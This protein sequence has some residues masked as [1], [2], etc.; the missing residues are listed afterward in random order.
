[1]RFTK[2]VNEKMKVSQDKDVDELPGTQPS[3]YYSGVDKGDK[4]KRAKQFARQA[5]MSDDDP[6]AY[7]PAPG[8]KDTKTKPS[9]HTKKF[10]QMYGEGGANPAQQAAI[11][12]SKKEKAGKP[13][14]DKE[15]KSLKK[16]DLKGNMKHA[17][18]TL[19]KVW[20]RKKKLGPKHDIGYY[21]AQI[22][23]SYRDV[24]S[25]E[26]AKM[27][28]EDVSQ[29][30]INDLEKFADRIL[31]KF[32][33]D[34]EFTKHFVDR[35]NDKRN[36]PDIKVAELQ[37]LFKKIQKNKAK[38]VKD[39]E[40]IEAVLKDLSSDLNLPVV[41]KTKGD[42]IEL[43]NK[44]IMRKKD[45][46][47]PS[48]VIKYEEFSSM[49]EASRADMVARKRPHMLLK[50]GNQGVKFDGRF[51]MFKKKQELNDDEKPLKESL[52]DLTFDIYELMEATMDA[53]EEDSG[54]ALKKKAEKSGMPLGVLKK[55]FDRGVAAWRT[56]HRPGTTATQW[57]LARV[58]SFTT[59]S[60]GTWGKADKDLASKVRSESFEPHMMYDPKTGKG[61]KADKEAD[62]LKMKK[63]GYT[64]DKPKNEEVGDM[65]EGKSSTGYELYH[66]DFSSAM[67]HAYKHAKDKLKIEIDPNEIDDKVATGPRKPS[68]G[69]TNS[70][71]LTDKAGKKA[72]QIQ[73]Y[74]MDNKKYEL[75]MYK[76][77]LDEA[78]R[79]KRAPKMTGDS[80]AIQRAKDRAHNDAMGRTKTGRKKPVRTMT[81]TQRSLASLR[82]DADP[83]WDTHKQVGMKKK[84]NKMVP[85]CVPKNESEQVD[86]IAPVIGAIGK[87]AGGAAGAFIAKKVMK[88]VAKAVVKKAG[89]AA[90]GAAA[91]YV[92]G[93]VAG[94]AVNKARDAMSKK[95]DNNNESFDRMFEE[96]VQ[97]DLVENAKTKKAL[98]AAMKFFTKTSKGKNDRVQEK[99]RMAAMEMLRDTLEKAGVSERD[100][101]KAFGD[102]DG[103]IS[104]MMGESVEL[105]EKERWMYKGNQA[106]MVG[107]NLNYDDKIEY[108]LSKKDAET[109]NK[110]MKQAK[111][112]KDRGK[113]W[114]MFSSS[115]E[116][117]DRAKGPVK[118]IA[119]A[120]KMTKESLDEAKLMSDDDVAKMVAK[121]LGN[122]KNTDSYDQVAAIKSILNKSPKQKRLATDREFIDDVLDILFKKYKFRSNQRE[123]VELDEMKQGWALIDTADGNKVKALSSREQ[124]VKQSKTSAERPPMSVKDKNTLKI[125][126]LKKAV[127]DKQAS[128]MIGYPLEESLEE[129]N[130]AKEYENYHSKPEQ[131]AKRSSRNSARRIMAKDEDVDGMDVG[132]KDNNPLN[133]DPKNLRLEKPSDNRREPRLRKEGAL[134][135][136][137][138]AGIAH[139]LGGGVMAKVAGGV[140]GSVAQNVMKKR[141]KNE[142]TVDEGISKK[143][144]KMA[145]GIASDKRYAGGNMTGAVKVIDKIRKGLSSHPQ[146][147]AV[148]RRQNEDLDENKKASLAKKLAKASQA[149]KKG[150][151]KVSLKKA[152]WEKKEE[153]EEL[154]KAE[155]K[156]IDQMY[157]K[158]GNLTAL[159]KKVMDAGKKK[160]KNED[161][162]L[163]EGVNDPS[164]FK[165]VFLAGG[166]GSGK[167]FL[168]GKTGL[169][170][171]GLKLINSD[172]AFEKQLKK[173]G[174]TATPEDI[175]T[176]KGQAARA[177]AKAMTAKQQELAL[178]GRLGLVIDGTGKDYDKISKQVVDMKK[179]GYDVA[180]IF[181]NT[182]LET[183]IRRDQDRP[184]TLGRKQVTQ[185]WNEVQENIGKFQR[186]FGNML[187]VVDNSDNSNWEHGALGA[188]KDIT[189]WVNIPAKSPMAKKWIKTQKD[190]RGMTEGVPE[191]GTPETTEKFA[192]MTPGEKFAKNIRFKKKK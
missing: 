128:R 134:G 35:M 63:M 179:I 187:I 124:G 47:T 185:M 89:K 114:D 38:D 177:K 60:A 180:M 19:Q 11:A 16:E 169:P 175:F 93:K 129:R 109:L 184:R 43:V 71:R 125:V 181:V 141:K 83:C 69:K 130:Y 170:A 157:D 183:A 61:Y 6:K 50:A 116:T 86:E 108:K 103:K 132:H 1:M 39:N 186:L 91:G 191:Y 55:V 2:F 126:K 27:V 171:L 78:P 66:K 133:N 54:E 105:S 136:I 73:V 8:D 25:K 68:K 44:T 100:T 167:S 159:G 190:A 13:G 110:F 160:V 15:G 14:Y 156:L 164:I 85:D 32:K 92:A 153:L 79:R 24:N 53:I 122:K 163:E 172:P 26:L 46:K 168:V 87:V 119:L 7:K 33:I 52:E 34:V 174:L 70:Y 135:A 106:Y 139:A 182:N 45:F 23:R 155:M 107:G 149:S 59:K 62:H 143:D 4:E 74:N 118:A 142:K 113:V 151:A 188:Y 31:G 65:K 48:K 37:K 3:K 49:D 5:K 178:A 166:P 64:H 9:S 81:S 17:A 173:V 121:K 98:D 76:E 120:K 84:G 101:M 21:A 148:L 117:G 42:E 10:K 162:N 58:N 115:K 41:I 152:P 29:K 123:S 30:Q 99:N 22:A 82:D 57:G 189:K 161:F 144:I 96:T 104:K 94:H 131:I 51:K 77:D 145:I 20:D 158:K 67:Q 56:G 192:S 40:G 112:D 12:I 88:K 137:A 80:V 138:G 97:Q 95:K 111:N 102:L 147:A 140:A 176:P 75:N 150:K 165:V 18:M 154:T 28:Q 90:A 72:V 146:V 127:G 36:S